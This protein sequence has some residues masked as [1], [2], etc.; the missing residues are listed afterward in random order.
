MLNHGLSL[1]LQRGIPPGGAPPSTAALILSPAT[2]APGVAYN[3]LIGN[4]LPGST[5]TATSSDG[6]VLTIAGSTLSG[7][8]ATAGA[9]TITLVETRA[10]ALGSPRTTLVTVTVA[11]SLAVQYGRTPVYNAGTV[12]DF[13]VDNV[14]GLDTNAGTS[15]AAPFATITAAFAANV[16]AGGNKVI[17]VRDRGVKYREALTTTIPVRFSGYGTEHAIISGQNLITGWTVCTSAQAPTVGPNFANIFKATVLK[18]SLA[19]TA[20]TALALCENDVILNLVQRRGDQTNL[21]EQSDTLSFFAGGTSKT[22]LTSPQYDST[23]SFTLDGS[24]PA[25][26]STISMSSMLP[27]YSDAALVNCK[28]MIKA[29]PNVV[30]LINVQSVLGGVLTLDPATTAAPDQATPTSQWYFSLLNILP[31]ISQGQWGYV[32]NATTLDLYLWPNSQADLASGIEI[33]AREYCFKANNTA[34]VRVD[35]LQFTGTSYQSAAP[36]VNG[37]PVQFYCATGTVSGNII[38]ECRIYNFSHGDKGYGSILAEAQSNFILRKNN[39]E[40]GQNNFGYFLSAIAT[41]PT[42]ARVTN[43]RV[44]RTSQSPFRHYSQ[45]VIGVWDNQ[46]DSCGLASHANKMNF[47]AGCD[48]ILAMRNDFIN[49]GG[50]MTIQNASRFLAL[51]NNCPMDPN[52][53]SASPRAYADQ[54]NSVS[55]GMTIPSINALINNSF[56]SDPGNHGS[57]G[58]ASIGINGTSKDAIQ[59]ADAAHQGVGY[60]VYNNLTAGIS[61]K[62]AAFTASMAG[63]I[64]SVSKMTQGNIRVGDTITGVGV[65]LVTIAS[66]PTINNSGNSGFVGDYTFTGL[67]QTVPSQAMMSSGGDVSSNNITTRS[68]SIISVLGANDEL[69]TDAALFV[70]SSTG[71]YRALVGSLVLTKV[72]RDVSVEIAIWQGYFPDANFTYD[73]AGNPWLG[74]TAG[75][76]PGIGPW[77]KNWPS[78]APT[79]SGT[80]APAVI[81]SSYS[82]ALTVIPAGRA[83]TLD[84]ASAAF[85]AAHSIVHDGFGNF[86]SGAV[87]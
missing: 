58:G 62:N 72:G 73:L 59:F 14:S 38:E 53:T 24:I 67:A 60:R 42:G 9:K 36:A 81:G 63:N 27:T 76:D 48:V 4:R 56:R 86:S 51:M 33:N 82:A 43:N 41:N 15:I 5:I 50:Y 49:C 26:V 30:A 45:N 79:I 83:I 13:F 85:I 8:F 55:V 25:K 32:E 75:S 7:T 80:L 2:A 64:L 10:G 61:I 74:A 39:I 52:P 16:T 66:L 87:T 31:A 21:F 29:Y 12:G 65:T 22:V 3:A 6:T 11:V 18:S 68:G 19:H 34:G 20:F 17:R 1:Y 57:V 28:V 84:A 44:Y 69:T 78:T 70:N 71:D 46:A 54:T 37:S 23:L 77:G 47:Y 40:S 35:G